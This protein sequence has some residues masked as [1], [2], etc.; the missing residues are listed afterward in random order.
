MYNKPELEMA[1]V[2]INR[3][4]GKHCGIAQ[5]KLPCSK[6]EQ[7]TD[8]CNSMEEPQKHYNKQ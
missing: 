2:S 8:S 1:P 5:W 4:M 6:K 7:T 3:N